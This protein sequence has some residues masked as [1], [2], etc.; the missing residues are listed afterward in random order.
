MVMISCIKEVMVPFNG[1]QVSF[2]IIS[3]QQYEGSAIHF[4]QYPVSSVY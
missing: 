2:Q 3:I 1:A 4:L